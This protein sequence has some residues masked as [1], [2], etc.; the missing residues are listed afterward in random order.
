MN[1]NIITH[2]EWQF[3]V[4]LGDNSFAIAQEHKWGHIC[5]LGALWSEFVQGV[6]WSEILF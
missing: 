3:K 5:S 2:R 1:V 4:F 6:R